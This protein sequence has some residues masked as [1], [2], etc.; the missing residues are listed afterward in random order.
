MQPNNPSKKIKA[1]I[2]HN[3]EDFEEGNEVELLLDDNPIL[4]NGRLVDEDTVLV[5]PRLPKSGRQ[6]VYQND[7]FLNEDENEGQNNRIQFDHNHNLRD[8]GF[9]VELE[10]AESLINPPN[11]NRDSQIRKVTEKLSGKKLRADEDLLP[12]GIELQKRVDEYDESNRFSFPVRRSKRSSGDPFAFLKETD[13]EYH[14]KEPLDRSLVK[15]THD[16]HEELRRKL[17]P[18]II[19]SDK[20]DFRNNDQSL[21]EAAQK[22]THNRLFLPENR[23]LALH[24]KNEEFVDFEA[25]EHIERNPFREQDV[26]PVNLISGN[27]V[28][29]YLANRK[30]ATRS[31]IDLKLPSDLIREI[32]GQDSDDQMKAHIAGL[33]SQLFGEMEV[34][35]DFGK[36]TAAAIAHLKRKGLFTTGLKPETQNSDVQVNDNHDNDTEAQPVKPKITIEYR[37]KKGRLL[38]PKEAFKQMSWKFHGTRPKITK[39]LKKE[40][41]EREAYNQRARSQGDNKLQRLLQINQQVS[42]QPF[43]QLN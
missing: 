9:L 31:A 20:D 21:S 35:E 6:A 15:K 1:R 43:M 2:L 17:K 40:R 24:E 29:D 19:I 42:N 16:V 5:N 8:K 41:K 13:Q 26:T 23:D 25:I 10:D 14:V 7:S 32:P 30:E 3:I 27:S 33:P 34:Q 36:S 4:E 37:D 22:E 18:K 39:M 12:S 38:T 11:M 28:R